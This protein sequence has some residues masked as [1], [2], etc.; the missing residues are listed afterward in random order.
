[1]K[2]WSQLPIRMPREL[3]G[4]YYDLLTLAY[5]MFRNEDTQITIKDVPDGIVDPAVLSCLGFRQ[6]NEVENLK[7]IIQAEK[8]GY[9]AVAGAC[10]F[11]SGIRAASTLLSIPVVGAAEASMHLAAM[12]GNKFAVITSEPSW[13]S[14]MEHHLKVSGFTAAAISKQPVRALTLPMNDLFQCLMTGDHEPV[15][16]D[17]IKV[18]ELCLN[19]GADVIIAGCGLVSPILTINNLREIGGAPVIDP[20]IASLKMAELM[21]N[22]FK[23]GLPVKTKKGLFQTLPDELR[24][25]GLDEL[26]LLVD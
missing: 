15:K 19:D 22:F 14:E 26:N 18:A 7:S 23:S 8:E 21:G 11:D 16:E 24:I 2:I 17:F 5:N 25:K 12:M 3:Y 1:M 4:N 10:Y 9:D 13:T 6:I 20:M